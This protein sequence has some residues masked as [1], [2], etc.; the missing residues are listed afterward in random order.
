M[1]KCQA[2]QAAY[3]AKKAESDQTQAVVNQLCADLAAA[4]MANQ[5][6][7]METMQAYQAWQACLNKP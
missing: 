6:A 3:D 1:T 7:Q 5:Q 2:E 4:T